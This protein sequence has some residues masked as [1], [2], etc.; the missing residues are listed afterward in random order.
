MVKMCVFGDSITWG[1]DDTEKEGWV[2]RIRHYFYTSIPQYKVYNMGIHGDTSKDL[3]ERFERESKVRRPDTIL[4]AIGIND[5]Q[6][7]QDIKKEK[8]LLAEFNQNLHDIIKLAK[9]QTKKIGIIGLTRVFEKDTTP[10]EWNNNS[11]YTNKSIIIYDNALKQ[12]AQE[13]NLPY[14]YMFDLL[15]ESDVVDGL[16]PTAKGHEKMF[17]RIK[18]FILENNKHQ[19]L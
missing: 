13:H 5:S 4:I 10:V 16:H 3:L 18:T 11:H 7:F 19:R 2:N 1:S 17:E 14:L 6:T 15:E 9:K 8:V 12:I